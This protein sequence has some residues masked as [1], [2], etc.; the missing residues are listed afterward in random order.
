MSWSHF[1]MWTEALERLQ[2]KFNLGSSLVSM[3][4]AAVWVN[5]SIMEES[6]EREQI[7][8]QHWGVTYISGAGRRRRGIYAMIQRISHYQLAFQ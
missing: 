1:E 5:E 4:M 3:K 2:L 6:T 8:H 7:S